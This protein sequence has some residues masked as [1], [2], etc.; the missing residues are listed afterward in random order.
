MEVDATAAPGIYENC[1]AFSGDPNRPATCDPV[2]DCEEVNVLP[3]GPVGPVKGTLTLDGNSEYFPEEQFNYQ[4]SWRNSGTA[5]VDGTIIMDLMPPEIE[6]IDTDPGTPGIQM[7]VSYTNIPGSPVVTILENQGVNFDQT[8]I[9]WDFT[10]IILPGGTDA[11][12]DYLSDYFRIKFLVQVKS[13]VEA[14]PVS[15]SF[16]LDA[17]IPSRPDLPLTA[18]NTLSIS[19]VGPGFLAKFYEDIDEP[20]TFVD[21]LGLVTSGIFFPEEE[22]L[23]TLQW[24]NRGEFDMMNTMITDLLPPEIELVDTDPGTA[25]IQPDVAY[26][27]NFPAFP[28]APVITIVEN[29]GNG[30][31]TQINWD[32]T[33]ITLEGGNPS[34][35]AY[36][37]TFRVR[38]KTG[39]PQGTITNCFEAVAT[40]DNVRTDVPSACATSPVDKVGPVRL[41]KNLNDNDNAA[42]PGDIVEYEISF[43]NQGPF[44][45]TQVK[46][47]DQLPPG[48]EYVD[49]S[50][51]YD[52]VSDPGT[53]FMVTTTPTN[54]GGVDY[55][56]NTLIWEWP[57]IPGA[58]PND[59]RSD[60][61]T[62]TYQAMVLPT[63]PPDLFLE[64]C[65]TLDAQGPNI[66][67]RR[68]F[69][70]PTT[71]QI[72]DECNDN[73]LVLTLA[74]VESEKFVW[75]SCDDINDNNLPDDDEF[76]ATP[77]GGFAIGKTTPGS[78]FYYHMD[79]YN[80]GNIQIKDLVV[81]D[82][83]PWIGDIGVVVTDP[84]DSE[85]RANM[86]EPFQIPVEFTPAGGDP[87]VTTGVKVYYTSETNPCRVEFNPDITPAGCTGP[88]WT[89]M[90]PADLTEIQAFKLEFNDYII[91][92]GQTLSLIWRMTAPIDAP[93]GTT[94]WNTF[95]YQGTRVDNDNTFT[96][97]QPKKVGMLIEECYTDP[98]QIG[99]YV[100]VD[101]N[102][103]GI[104]NEG[105]EAGVNGVKVTLFKVVGAKDTPGNGETDD[106]MMGMATTTNNQAGEPGYYLFTDLPLDMDYYAVFDVDDQNAG[107]TLPNGT[108]ITTQ[109]AGDDE[110][111]SDPDP[112][113]GM[114]DVVTLSTGNE[115]NLSLDM[116]LNP[117]PDCG[118]DP[119]ITVICDNEGTPN[120]PS[121][122]TFTF[123]ILVSTNGSTD[124][125]GEYTIFEYDENGA[126]TN[127]TYN[128]AYDV[129][130]GPFGPF[131][132]S[133]GDISLDVDDES[134]AICMKSVLVEAPATMQLQNLSVDA[135]CSSA[136]PGGYGLTV[137]LEIFDGLIP[138]MEILQSFG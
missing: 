48:L 124:L 109:N 118:A 59:Y 86:A 29:T 98:G 4:L 17:P 111:D 38:I 138:L 116:G 82:I 26:S 11:A 132:V 113:M 13:G 42:F 128:N 94:A 7:D 117:V 114:T 110:L 50:V 55:D 45:A 85:W 23:Y 9:T 21:E 103:D 127:I 46:I 33:G 12:T 133:G 125:A 76:L 79:I 136:G 130:Q 15:N 61:I 129:E 63:A 107:G 91:Q 96:T 47:I 121:D 95:G 112:A 40:G 43:R 73:L 49:G 14:G 25:G 53:G 8:K 78:D 87:N 69:S 84:R 60:R 37:I 67:P 28:P 18:S 115:S 6:L 31:Q 135:S 93:V 131:D 54:V 120:D 89:D 62:I 51:T 106:M 39:T 24:N 56:L 88:F 134:N 35:P 99:N 30:D 90:A 68:D 10:G 104:Q 58:D 2:E 57:T 137:D 123:T 64:N 102:G 74:K 97:A 3:S 32:F 19:P 108:G 80:A 36:L 52:N 66:D 70:D 92:P 5:G 122:D 101:Q 100:W 16:T 126:L 34:S 83:L 75:G 119:V 72:L 44:D 22:F 65:V 71:P 20:M 77:Q 81:I 27:G 41:Q 1:A 105:P